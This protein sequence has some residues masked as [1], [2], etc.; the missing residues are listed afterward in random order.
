MAVLCA[1]HGVPFY[2]AAPMSTIDPKTEWDKVPVEERSVDEVVKIKGK[3]IAPKGVV[4][5]NPAFD[6]TPPDLITALIT[7]RGVLTPPYGE[8]ISRILSNG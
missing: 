5:L 6:I 4:V 2:T 3:R 7:E 1:R 8:S